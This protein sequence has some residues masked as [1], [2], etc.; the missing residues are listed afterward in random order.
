MKMIVGLGNPGKQYETTRHNVGFIVLD[1]VADKIGA[2]VKE[3]KNN[4]FIGEVFFQ[5]EKVLLVKPQTY[6]NLSG[7]CVGELA[8]YYKIDNRDILVISDDLSLPLGTMKLRPKGSSGGHNGLKSLIA[9]LGGDD[10]PR[11]KIGIGHGGSEGVIEHVLGNFPADEWQKLTEIMAKAADCA[12]LWLESGVDAA[13]CGY[14]MY[15]KL[16]KAERDSTESGQD[17]TPEPAKPQKPKK[18]LKSLM[19]HIMKTDK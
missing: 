8:R 7:Q 9:H 3:R 6:M 15:A 5:G 14:N 1:L 4:G 13:M 18:A 10:F 17:A 12:L 19:E 16:P 11:L 2:E